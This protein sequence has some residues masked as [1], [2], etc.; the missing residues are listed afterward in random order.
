FTIE[1]LGDYNLTLDG[2]PRVQIIGSYFTLTQTPSSPIAPYNETTFEIEFSPP[3]YPGE[4]SA[5]VYIENDDPDDDE[6]PYTFII[7]GTCIGGIC[8]IDNGQ[9]VMHPD[10]IIAPCEGA[11]YIIESGEDIEFRAGKLI[12]LKHGFW[13]KAGSDFRA[14]IDPSL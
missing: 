6:D 4:R 7:S 13:A 3:I 12:I 2:S 10:S 1:N 8:A 11:T 9:D 14:H 5:Q